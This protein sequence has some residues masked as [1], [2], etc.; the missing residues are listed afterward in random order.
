M[1][2]PKM[3]IKPTKLLLSGS[4]SQTKP[5]FHHNLTTGQITMF[6]QTINTTQNKNRSSFEDL[7]SSNLSLKSQQNTCQKEV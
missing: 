7:L 4:H 6:H 2:M 1:S 3:R 5:L